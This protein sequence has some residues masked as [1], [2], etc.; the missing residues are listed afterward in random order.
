MKIQIEEMEELY[1]SQISTVF[2]KGF[3]KINGKEIS[4]RMVKSEFGWGLDWAFCPFLQNNNE[5]EKIVLLLAQACEKKLGKL[6]EKRE[7]LYKTKFNPQIQVN[8]FKL[9]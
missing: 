9:L 1:L 3:F 7:H 2:A 8:R 5:A 4:F 6:K